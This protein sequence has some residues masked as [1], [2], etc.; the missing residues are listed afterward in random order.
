MGLQGWLYKR[1]WRLCKS[2]VKKDVA[3]PYNGQHLV[4]QSLDQGIN[5]KKKEREEGSRDS[6]GSRGCAEEEEEKRG[7]GES[8]ILHNP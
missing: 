3:W 4:R 5:K 2:I 1:K 8:A 6:R 7:G